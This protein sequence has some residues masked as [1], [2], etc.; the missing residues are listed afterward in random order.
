MPAHW[1]PLG[2]TQYTGTVLPPAWRGALIVASHG[3]WN[4]ESGQVGRLIARAELRADGTIAAV[5]PAVGE[6]GEGG[7]LRQ[8]DWDVRPVD[9]KQG[10]DGALYFTDDSGGRVFRIGAR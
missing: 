4:H 7:S 6:R 10:P 9:V 1:A 8:G 2:L 3:S 5:T